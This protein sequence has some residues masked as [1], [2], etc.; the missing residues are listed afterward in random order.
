L[1]QGYQLPLNAFHSFWG[2]VDVTQFRT[3]AAYSIIVIVIVVVIVIVI[4]IVIII[5]IRKKRCLE[6]QNLLGSYE[7]SE[8]P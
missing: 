1:T 2:S 7:N 3:V 5:K 6:K 4:V 8:G